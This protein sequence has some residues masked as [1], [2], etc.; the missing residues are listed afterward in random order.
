MRIPNLPLWMIGLLAVGVANAQ[1]RETGWEF[2][3]DVLYQGHENTRSEHGSDLAFDT[4]WGGS[5]GAQYRFTPYLELG[6]MVDLLSI[7]YDAL[8]QRA[9]IT[10]SAAVSDKASVYTP[11]FVG[12]LNFLDHPFT[13]YVNAGLGWTFLDTD[14]TYVTGPT[15]NP[16]ACWW[17]PWAGYICGASGSSFS[18]NGFA[19]D[20]G[21]GFRWDVSQKFSMRLAY[22]KHWINMGGETGTPNLDQFRLGLQFAY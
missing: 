7:N 15:V 2:R 14:L 9:D 3:G 19:Y 21:A 12:N 20:I 13:P 16:L 22:E 11:R 8:V 10:G 1:T 5:L 6:F 17:D 4:S 18:N